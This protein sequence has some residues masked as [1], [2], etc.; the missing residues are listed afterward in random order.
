MIAYP[1]NAGGISTRIFDAGRAEDPVILLVHGLSSRADRWVRN[2]DALADSGFRVIAPD[3]PGHG[4]AAKRPEHDHTIGGY[5]DFLLNLLDALKINRAT[6][7]GTSMGGHVVAAAALKAPDRVERL[8]MI[9]TTGLSPSTP[10]R[11]QGFRD[12]IMHLTPES[13][14]PRLERVFTDRTLASDDMVREDVLI[15]TSPGASACFDRFITYM[16]TSYNEDLVLDRLREIEDKVPLL[17]FWGEDDSSV[18]VAI[19]HKAREALPKSRLVCV[20]NINHTPY[21]ENPTLFND[22]LLK[23]MAGRIDDA[24]GQ[25]LTLY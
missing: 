3:L 11:A 19:G 15:N 1:V 2:I 6:F 7:V 20:K 9:G 21:Y 23:F 18:S 22:V 24:H 14:R 12:W 8:M 25:G 17:L 16:A 4:F 10:E 13:H 5:S